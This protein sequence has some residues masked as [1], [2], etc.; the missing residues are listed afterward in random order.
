MSSN[1]SKT[2][3]G[4]RL[5]QP[6]QRTDSEVQVQLAVVCTAE[7]CRG[8]TRWM[9]LLGGRT[10]MMYGHACVV[11]LGDRSRWRGMTASSQQVTDKTGAGLETG[12]R[13]V[14]HV[15]ASWK[16]GSAALLFGISRTAWFRR[17]CLVGWLAAARLRY[18]FSLRFSRIHL[19]QTVHI[20]LLEHFHF[21]SLTDSS[22]GKRAMMPGFGRLQQ[23]DEPAAFHLLQ[24]I[25]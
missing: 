6:C 17:G 12:E 7:A 8:E 5:A 4:Q 10:M 15:A 21:H 24:L 2:A 1:L 14:V 18:L 22:Q 16:V 25:D 3:S 23:T 11:G 19:H 13:V 9:G 20:L